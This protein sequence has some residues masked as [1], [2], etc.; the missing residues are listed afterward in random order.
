MR[1]GFSVKRFRV[2]NLNDDETADKE[3]RHDKYRTKK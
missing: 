2:D 3:N 1:L